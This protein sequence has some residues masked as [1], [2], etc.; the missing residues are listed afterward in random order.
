MWCTRGLFCL[1]CL[2]V[3]ISALLQK[4]MR[5]GLLGEGRLPALNCVQYKWRESLCVVPCSIVLP[6]HFGGRCCIITVFFKLYFLEQNKNSRAFTFSGLLFLFTVLLPI[7]NFFWYVKAC[8]FVLTSIMSEGLPI[9][10]S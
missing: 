6:V 1:T 5:W 9:Q 8:F 4:G 7:I 10:L 2:S 3:C